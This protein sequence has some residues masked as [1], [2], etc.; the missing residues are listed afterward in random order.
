MLHS[1]PI[2]ESIISYSHFN[3]LDAD[4]IREEDQGTYRSDKLLISMIWSKYFNVPYVANFQM[5][6]FYFLEVSFPDNSIKLLTG[7]IQLNKLRVV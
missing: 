6:V 5:K 7:L 1:L 2:I 4:S 3:E